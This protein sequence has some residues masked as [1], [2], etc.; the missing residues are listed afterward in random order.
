MTVARGAKTVVIT[1]ASAGIGAEA[2]A[3]LAEAGWR[4]AV[5]GR[6]QE[7]T[8]AVATAVG[9]TPFYADYDRLDDVR[10]LA[11]A[12]LKKYARI[13]VLLN[14]AGGLVSPRRLS[15]DGHERTFQHNHLAPFLLTGLLRD[16]LEKNGGRVVS[17]SSIMNLIGDVRITDLEWEKRAWLGGW[18]AYGTAKLETVLFMRELA[19]RSTLE[20]YA[21]HPGYVATGFGTDSA[22]IR[23]SAVLKSGGFGIPVAEGAL[24]L[25]RLVS[26][27]AV[28]AANG[29]YFD[30]LHPNGRVAKGGTD[31]QLAAELW[32]RT[33]TLVGLG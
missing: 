23:L 2:A 19:K 1:G 25:I 4:I 22:L 26:D 30:R 6:N 32:E 27:P 31:D 28:N 21:V 11:S 8:D 9:G 10:A 33:S 16:R 13:D 12:L 18:K 3:R 5:V 15:E 24:P 20:A 29:S 17:T 7:R 14:N